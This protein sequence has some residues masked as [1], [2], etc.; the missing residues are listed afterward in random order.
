MPWGISELMFE[1]LAF[2][3]F[4]GNMYFQ[5]RGNMISFGTNY[6]AVIPMA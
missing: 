1:Y 4:N 3:G 6:S 5:M 2:V